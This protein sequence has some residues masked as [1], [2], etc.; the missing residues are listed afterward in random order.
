[1]RGQKRVGLREERRTPL[2]DGVGVMRGRRSTKL[3]EEKGKPSRNGKKVV[4][5]K[6]PAL[7]S[8]MA[9]GGG[10]RFEYGEGEVST[11]ASAK[12]GEKGKRTAS[13]GPVKQS[14]PVGGEIESELWGSPCRREG[15]AEM[16]S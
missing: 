5:A 15:V 16:K 2:G 1:L 4:C 11:A 12:G 8:A 3:W 14:T 9:L 13:L 6:P 7:S 10:C